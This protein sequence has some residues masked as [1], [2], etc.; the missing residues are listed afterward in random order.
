MLF[1]NVTYFL[2]FSY[3]KYIFTA[4]ARA[5]AKSDVNRGAE[6]VLQM[7]RQHVAAEYSKKLY[8]SLS[9]RTEAGIVAGEGHGKY[10][11]KN[12]QKNWHC[13]CIDELFVKVN[14]ELWSR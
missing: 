6:K 12:K 8:Q 9:R 1:L 14:E 11:D 7:L 13:P 4:F 10:L 2:Y 3:W 5:N